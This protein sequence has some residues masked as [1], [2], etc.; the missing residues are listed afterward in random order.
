MPHR[1]AR[2]AAP[3]APTWLPDRSPGLAVGLVQPPAVL[4]HSR[5]S[6][7]QPLVSWLRVRVYGPAGKVKVV[8]MVVQV[9]QLPV[10]G[11]VRWR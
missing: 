4:S 5:L 10:A 1:D 9:C 11:R 6:M 2:R 7:F 3:R 8:V